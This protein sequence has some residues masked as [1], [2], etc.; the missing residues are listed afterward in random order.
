MNNEVYV[1]Y[2][3]RI[4]GLHLNVITFKIVN[5]TIYT[6][7]IMMRSDTLFFQKRQEQDGD[8]NL[9]NQKNYW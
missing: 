2:I 4:F 1:N 6:E 8:L 3:D 9:P 7:L 5:K